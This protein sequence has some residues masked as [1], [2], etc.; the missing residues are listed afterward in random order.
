MIAHELAA[1]F[2]ALY[3]CISLYFLAN[4]TIEL[5]GKARRPGSAVF[6]AALLWPVTILAVAFMAR[7]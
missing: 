7:E 1:V 4:C 6:G 3:L 2:V 5:R